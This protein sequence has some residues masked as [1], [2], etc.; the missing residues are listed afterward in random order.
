MRQIF[1]EIKNKFFRG[2]NRTRSNSVD[3]SYYNVGARRS[4][5]V[6]PISEESSSGFK[7]VLYNCSK[8]NKRLRTG[9]WLDCGHWKEIEEGDLCRDCQPNLK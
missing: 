8:C 1:H 4:F 3:W 9:D 6:K 5:N 2:S 7:L